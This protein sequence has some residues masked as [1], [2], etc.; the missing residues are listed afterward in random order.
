M[1]INPPDADSDSDSVWASE[2]AR[3]VRGFMGTSLFMPVFFY[4]RCHVLFF[5]FCSRTPAGV[6]SLFYPRLFSN[7][8][9]FNVHSL[10]SAPLLQMSLRQRE[11]HT[12][13]VP[14]VLPPL[15]P[16]RGESNPLPL[17]E[18]SAPIRAS[19]VPGLM[20]VKGGACLLEA[21]SGSMLGCHMWRPGRSLGATEK[22]LFLLHFTVLSN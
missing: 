19:P 17:A 20:L 21:G 22:V 13:Q 9:H 5:F 8:V 16:R 14:F 7:P 3:G 12:R 4:A 6:Q 11:P 10:L 2:R 15:R 18:T 1:V